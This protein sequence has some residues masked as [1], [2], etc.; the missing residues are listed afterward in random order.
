MTQK[1][2]ILGKLFTPISNFRS[3]YLGN[4]LSYD[5]QIL[6][7]K[8]Y[9]IELFKTQPFEAGTRFDFQLV[10]STASKRLEL[11][12][13]NFM[14]NQSQGNTKLYKSFSR[15]GQAIRHLIG[16]R[17]S[18]WI[19]YFSITIKVRGLEF[20]VHKPRVRIFIVYKFR[21]NQITKGGEIG[22]LFSL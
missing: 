13:Q 8:R 11:E 10:N 18:S 16:R 7:A 22:N 21:K 2:R 1:T 3:S 20:N 6:C 19:I 4:G 9:G 15:I 12:L 5:A 17:L 14:W